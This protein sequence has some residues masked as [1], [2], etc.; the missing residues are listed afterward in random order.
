MHAE[1]VLLL[2][3]AAVAV[4][5]AARWLAGRTGVPAAA[6]LTV[7]GLVYA[8][9]PGPN[10]T[11]DPEIV[12]TVLLPPLLYSAALDSS[13]IAIRANMRTVVGL[14]VL[15]VLVTALVIG[16]G[17]ALWVPG[18][19]LAAGIA[20][21][22][23]VAPPDPVAALAVGRRVGLPPRLVTL[24]QGEG[25]LNDATALTLLSVAVAAAVGDGFST[26]SAL[27]QFALAAAGGVA[28]GLV[29]AYGVRP[30]RRLRRDPLASNAISLATPF[31]AYLLAES[32]HVS[33]VLAVVVAGLVIAHNAPYWQSGATRLQTDAVW[34]L[35]DFLLEG[36]VFL[37]IGQQLP[38][39]IRGLGQYAPSTVVVAS[40]ITVGAVLLVRPLW[41]WLT[42]HAPQ[43]LHMR[44]S[45]APAADED[46]D[47]TTPP[48]QLSGRE[49]AVLSWAGTRGVISLAAVFTI[50]LT[51]DA[52]DPFPDRD[53]LLFCAFLAVLVTLVGQGATFAPLVRRL[54]LRADA[55]DA[56]RLRNQARV[57]AV[58]A[59]LARLDELQ[60]EQHDHLDDAAIESIR[61]ALRTRRTRY[62]RRL[63]VL[64]DAEGEVPMSPEYEAALRV[65]R[66]VI[67]A[68]R[69]EL[70]RWRDLGRLPDEGLRTLERELDHQEHLLPARPA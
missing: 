61:A 3:L 41:L 56:A 19:T 58:D 53:L 39:V 26:W 27:G 2:V 1:T 34:R 32:V 47:P 66:A 24:I 6:L 5:V 7:T 20:L 31:V 37:L 51:T 65:R 45:G 15:L 63:E 60:A 12:L 25:L 48:R 67:D 50:P 43:A 16:A 30:L 8:L 9:L 13:L 44:L 64:V 14:S 18:A 36:V 22:A 69:E 4:I 35:V 21:G 70:L 54:R 11:L 49:I 28:A 40:L 42:E 17:F 57:A 62:E 55:A 10:L 23:A 46:D 52:G 59:G 29:V 68:E 33:G 38:A